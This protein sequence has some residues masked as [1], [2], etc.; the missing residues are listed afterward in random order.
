MNRGEIRLSNETLTV[1]EP[2][3]V[4]RG[5]PLPPGAVSEEGGVCVTDAAGGV[6]PS[7]GRVLQRRPDGSIEWLLM[8]ILVDLAGQEAKSIFVETHAGKTAAVAHP[9]TVADDGEQVTLSNGISEVV[10]SRAR[11]SLIRRMT[12]HGRTFVDDGGV[13]D[14]L[15]ADGGGKKHRASLSGYRPTTLVSR[16]GRGLDR[17]KWPFEGFSHVDAHRFQ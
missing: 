2:Y 16:R 10:V 5:V 15:V 3:L 14:L 7:A 12:V 1:L 8:D 9:V 17:N 11:G 6:L 13:V 4:T